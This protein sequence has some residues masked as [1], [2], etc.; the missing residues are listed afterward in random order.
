MGQEDSEIEPH[1]VYILNSEQIQI[2]HH[3]LS[4]SSFIMYFI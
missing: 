1:G 3:H 2:N 4:S